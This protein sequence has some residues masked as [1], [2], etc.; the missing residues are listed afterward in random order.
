VWIT[1]RHGRELELR[2]VHIE[3]LS[4]RDLHRAHVHLDLE[5]A[6]HLAGGD[7]LVE[8]DSD[9]RARL[10][11]SAQEICRGELSPEWLAG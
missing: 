5:A 11:G 3:R 9:L 8:L 10:T 4:R 2:S 7:L 1:H 6:V